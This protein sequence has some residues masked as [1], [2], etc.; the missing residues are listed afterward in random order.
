MN[1]YL[2]IVYIPNDLYIRGLHQ[3]L[4]F[5]ETSE[6]LIDIFINIKEV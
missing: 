1:T 4:F 5:N 3:E 6:K 2:P